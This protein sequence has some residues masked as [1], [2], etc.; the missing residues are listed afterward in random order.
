[1]IYHVYNTRIVHLVSAANVIRTTAHSNEYF[2]KTKKLSGFSQNNGIFHHKLIFCWGICCD[3]KS[4][5]T[6]HEWIRAA[7]Y[8]CTFCSSPKSCDFVESHRPSFYNWIFRRK[9]AELR[10]LPECILH[11]NCTYILCP[12][13]K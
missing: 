13:P 1:M 7:F 5:G 3:T 12:S 9:A 8:D 2:S 11:W 6:C 4:S 10:I